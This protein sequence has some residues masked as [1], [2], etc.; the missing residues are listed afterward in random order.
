MHVAITGSMEVR[1]EPLDGRGNKG[2]M[3]LC[4]RLGKKALSVDAKMGMFEELLC[5]M[6]C[7]AVRH[8]F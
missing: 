6:F 2:F 5:Q 7:M 1:G 3:E 4:G 8:R